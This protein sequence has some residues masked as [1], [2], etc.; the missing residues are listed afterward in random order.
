MT[1][2]PR[3]NEERLSI[4]L[5]SLWASLIMLVTYMAL[6]WFWPLESIAALSFA[7]IVPRPTLMALAITIL[8]SSIYPSYKLDVYIHEVKSLK[9]SKSQLAAK[10]VGGYLAAL[11]LIVLA[12]YSIAIYYFNI[13]LDSSFTATLYTNTRLTTI[14][15]IGLLVQIGLLELQYSS[16][17]ERVNSR[18]HLK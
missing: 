14:L 11:I 1:K 10:Y 3:N 15:V 5:T 16:Y 8:L 17:L 12:T 18:S 2:I 13:Y 7:D 9:G 4:I 6:Q